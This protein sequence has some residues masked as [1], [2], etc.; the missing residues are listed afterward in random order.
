MESQEFYIRQATE[1]EARGP[2]NLEQLVSLAETGSVTPET[3]YYDSVAEC[4]VVIDDNLEMKSAVFPEA[5]KL[6]LRAKEN[7]PILNRA[8]S[9]TR[10]PISVGDMLAAAEGRT[11]D[12]KDKASMEIEALRAAGIGS[13]AVVA[14]F[15]LSSAGEALPAVD[16]IMAMDPAKLLAFPLVALGALDLLLAV[17]IGLGMMNLY[18][19]VRFR[20]ALGFGLFGMIFYLQGAH[21]PLIATAIGSAGFYFCTIS[22]SLLPVIVSSVVGVSGIGFVTY[23]LLSQ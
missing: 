22:V 3:L 12:T 2:F 1:T 15:V 17:L 21:L 20:A 4:W 16:A 9:N 14:M 8:S 6:R 13:W 10:P 5:K 7:M 23:H 18:P 11:D 19:F